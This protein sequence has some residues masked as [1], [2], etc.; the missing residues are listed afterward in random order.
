MHQDNG[1]EKRKIWFVQWWKKYYV[2]VISSILILIAVGIVLVAKHFWPFGEGALLNGDVLIQ[3]W[4]FIA[5]LRRKFFSGESLL[6]TWN[7]AYGS[8]FYSFLTYG[9]INP[10]TFILMLIPQRYF[11]H[12][13]TICVVILLLFMNGSMLYFLTHRPGNVLKTNDI[14]NMFFSLSYTLCMYVVSN[15]NNWTFLVVAVLFPLIILGLESFVADGR[16]KLYFV[17]LAL[18]IL[19]NYYFAALFCIFIVLYYFTLEFDS[20]NSFCQKSLKVFL[21]SVLALGVSGF[22][23]VPTAMIMFGQSYTKSAFSNQIWFTSFFDILKQFLAFNCAV[24]RG[25]NSD[26]FGEV[27]LYFGL[28]M[29]ML[30]TFY[31]FNSAID[32]KKRIKKLC[33]VVLYLLAFNTNILNYVMHLFH[34]PTWFPNRFSLFFTL[35]C[36]IMAYDSWVEM[37]RGEYKQMTIPK[38]VLLGIGWAG[39]TVLCFAFAREIKYEFTYYY[40][41][42]IFLFYMVAMLLLPYC[43]KVWPRILTV[44]GCIELILNFGYATIYRPL[45]YSVE[46]PTHYAELEEEAL[47]KGVGEELYGFSRVL[48]GNS[49]AAGKNGGWLHGIKNTALFSSSINDKLQ[50]FLFQIG[51]VAG[52]NY[53]S[54]YTYTPATMSLLNIQYIFYDDNMVDLRRSEGFYTEPTVI[55]NQYPKLFENENV[56][57][58]E[59]PTVLSVGYMVDS[60]ADEYFLGNE[61]DYEFTEYM[62]E[63]INTWVEAVSGVSDVLQPEE[64][65]INSIDLINC[66]GAVV[67][68]RY[69]ITQ[70][71]QESDIVEFKKQGEAINI[72][73]S[74][75]DYNQKESSTMVLDCEAMEAGDY[76]VEIGDGLR[77]VGYLEKGESFRIYYEGT[78]IDEGLKENIGLS[79]TIQLYRFDESQWQKAYEEISKQQMEVTDYS[80]SE[81]KGTID[82]SESGILFTSIPYDANW[83]LYIDDVETDI[84]PLW[85]EAFVGARLDTGTHHIRLV[86]RQR[87]LLLGTCISFLAIG[88]A[89]FLFIK[90]NKKRE[91]DA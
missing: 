10:I 36:I 31:F 55:Y 91:T 63:N 85:G 40:S 61:S 84:V 68:D 57:V 74:T 69:F 32:R 79:G 86:Y 4:P 72:D 29:L 19:F 47:Q 27:N 9:H 90:E 67:E 75:Q 64:L 30:T 62:A 5:E 16:W 50:L 54:P 73:T 24:D 59:N 42:M 18:A 21:T 48:E 28:L 3:T 17:T 34:Y 52:G 66:E 13:I 12:A 20:F 82:V 83:H 49:I 22:L 44:I 39:I 65:K 88:I 45:I 23:I 35:A 2:Y 58:Y 26:S 1:E 77:A 15:L 11:W 51:V 60:D 80:S 37:K 78:Y 25:S 38:G 14:S 76:Y 71:L 33:L 41:I 87:G 89:V 43:R 7:G 56:Y 46:G 53:I 81:L 6:F 70:T 8:N